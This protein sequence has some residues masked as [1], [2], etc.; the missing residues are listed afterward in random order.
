MKTFFR[1]FLFVSFSL[2]MTGQTPYLNEGYHYKLGA[3]YGSLAF[4]D[5]SYFT[6]VRDNS[7]PSLY[8]YT[9]INNLG[10]ISDSLNLSYPDS[11]VSTGLFGQCLNVNQDHLYN[12]YTKVEYGVLTN[13]WSIVLSKIHLDLSDTVET[14]DFTLAGYDYLYASASSFDSDSTFLITGS[15]GRLVGPD[16]IFKEELLLAKFDTSFNLIWYTVMQDGKPWDAAYG[17]YGLDITVDNNEGILVAGTSDFE[18]SP[19]SSFVA[20]F[21]SKTGDS[22]WCKE[23]SHINGIGLMFC[24]NRFDGNYQFLQRFY[25]KAN[26][27]DGYSKIGILDTLG[28]ILIE[29]SIGTKGGESIFNELIQTLD[30]NYYAA[31][32]H[33]NN[34]EYATGFKFSPQLDSLWQAFYWYDHPYDRSNI[35]AFR[36]KPNGHIIHLGNYQGIINPPPYILQTWLFETDEN[37][38]DT[39]GCNLGIE[40]KFTLETFEFSIS[41]NPNQGAF[42]IKFEEQIN[43]SNYQL[44][45]W[46]MLGRRVGNKTYWIDGNSMDIKVNLPKGVYQ[47]ILLKNG[48]VLGTKKLVLD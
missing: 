17:F 33:W 45:I 6:A 27:G 47:T 46:D 8:R 36:Q 30:G 32:V 43:R 7:E 2:Q 23:F 35:N 44:E 11:S 16:S 21:D 38:C 25:E 26:H 3:L 22:L 41:P 13:S 10:I 18:S 24:A 12:A 9:R 19:Y 34:G 39:S 31:G 5:S 20:R 40:N 28:N 15:V 29:K 37:G 42:K 1:I 4:N 48:N 14:K